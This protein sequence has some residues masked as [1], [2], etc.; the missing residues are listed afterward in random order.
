MSAT[1][2]VLGA[3]TA[4]LLLAGTSGMALAGG[5]Y[6]N[7][8]PTVTPGSSYPALNGHEQVPEDTNQAR[9]APPQTVAPTSFMQ[10]SLGAA[11]AASTASATAGAA[12]LNTVYG[13]ITSESISTAAGATYTLTLTNSTVNTSSN[14]QAAAYLKGSTTGGPLQVTSITP[15][16]GSV[17]IKVLNAGTAALNGTIAIPFQ[18][19]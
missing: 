13:T 11:I 3:L 8:V 15:G 10:A 14:V 5:T 9:G 18:T 17:V 2:K 7:G 16:S 1:R 6:T 4:A 12:T 19:N